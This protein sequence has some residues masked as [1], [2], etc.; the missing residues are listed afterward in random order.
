M[1]DTLRVNVQYMRPAVKAGAVPHVR[2]GMDYDTD[3]Y[4]PGLDCSVEPSKA[5]QQFKDECDINAIMRRYET[6]GRIDWLN[7][8]DPEWGDFTGIPS[9]HDALEAVRRAQED[10]DE[11]PAK[12]RDEFDNDPAKFVAF[13]Q[14]EKNYDRAVELGLVPKPEDPPGPMEVRIVDPSPPPP[15]K[16]GDKPASGSPGKG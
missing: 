1:K 15:P 7:S 2:S 3:K 13:M 11:M 16:A 14:D 12:L 9:Y 6:T 10:F 4:D 8:R 5:Q